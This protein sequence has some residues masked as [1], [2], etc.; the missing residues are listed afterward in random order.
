MVEHGLMV[1]IVECISGL[2][3]SIQVADGNI[4]PTWSH[5]KSTGWPRNTWIKNNSD[6]YYVTNGGD[7]YHD[8]ANYFNVPLNFLNFLSS[9]NF[10]ESRNIK[11][12]FDIH[13]YFLCKYKTFKNVQKFL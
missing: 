7:Y 9:D 4:I 6:Y 12:I 1:Y 8:A 3:V 10:F 11:I 2:Q 5:F 13:N